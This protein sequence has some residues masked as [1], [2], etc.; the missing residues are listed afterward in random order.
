[1]RI[2]DVHIGHYHLTHVRLRVDQHWSVVIDP[3]VLQDVG[4]D[5]QKTQ[6]YVLHIHG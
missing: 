6:V 4:V 1:M 5:A 3:V 2:L